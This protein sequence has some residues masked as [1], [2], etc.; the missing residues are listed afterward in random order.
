MHLL[1]RLVVAGL[2]APDFDVHSFCSL[3]QPSTVSISCCR[4]LLN[5]CSLGPRSLFG[6]LTYLIDGTSVPLEVA[7]ERS[8]GGSKACPMTPPTFR[9]LQIR[10]GTPP[11]PYVPAAG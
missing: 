5:Q 8:I 4:L 6:R 2:G 1:H 10:K 3:S 7:A 9:P 11:V